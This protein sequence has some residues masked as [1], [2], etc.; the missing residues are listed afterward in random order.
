MI[1]RF[2]HSRQNHI[3]QN[4]AYP[5]SAMPA[6]IDSPNFNL[7][8]LPPKAKFL[9]RQTPGPAHEFLDDQVLRE[10]PG[11]GA[12]GVGIR[13]SPL[14]RE[15]DLRATVRD[16]TMNGFLTWRFMQGADV[17][18]HY[19]VEPRIRAKTVIRI[20]HRTDAKPQPQPACPP[21]SWP[22]PSL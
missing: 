20:D 18:V 7:D 17:M 2:T 6:D 8:N 15:V 14:L 16:E 19:L 21:E 1:Q 3:N 4:R 22:F 12:P 5:E 13:L 11:L 9:A 10:Q